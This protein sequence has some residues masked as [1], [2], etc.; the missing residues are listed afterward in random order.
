MTSPLTFFSNNS[1]APVEP[2]K[3]IIILSDNSIV[4][5]DGLE[6]TK[7]DIMNYI[8]DCQILKNELKRIIS[9]DSQWLNLN[10][11]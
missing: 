3:E 4:V 6:L 8:I 5:V 2:E 1:T 10:T 9:G 11:V 7:K